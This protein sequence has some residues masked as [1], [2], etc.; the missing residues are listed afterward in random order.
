MHSIKNPLPR[1][2]R[3]RLAEKIYLLGQNPDDPTLD[4]K[5]MVGTSL[6]RMRVGNW[7]VIYDRQDAVK[8]IAIEKIKA[9]GDAYK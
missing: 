1:E 4:A 2:D 6:Y 5:P 7:R 8:I 9:R 3:T